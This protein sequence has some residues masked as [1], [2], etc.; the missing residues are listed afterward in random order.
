MARKSSPYR[1]EHVHPGLVTIKSC[2]TTKDG[3]QPTVIE[4]QTAP[5][6]GKGPGYSVS[7]PATAV[8]TLTGE[9]GG[10]NRVVSARCQLREG[11]SNSTKRCYFTEIV[12]TT[13][14]WTAKI[15]TQSTAGTAAT[16]SGPI[17][18]FEINFSKTA[19]LK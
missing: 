6:A 7:A 4:G 16:L 14:P 11:A 5:T 15:V 17:V 13:D 18:D 9:S 3:D 10:Y 8:Y 12:A 1:E 19:A 2:F